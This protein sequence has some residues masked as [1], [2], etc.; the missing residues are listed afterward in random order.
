MIHFHWTEITSTDTKKY[1]TSGVQRV[2]LCKS[3]YEVKL[4]LNSY[5]LEIKTFG[6]GSRTDDVNSK[7]IVLCICS[8]TVTSNNRG[9]YYVE[10]LKTE[11]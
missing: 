4:L 2:Q 11:P 10:N 6:L 3:I 8:Y 1:T 9:E 5:E 7:K